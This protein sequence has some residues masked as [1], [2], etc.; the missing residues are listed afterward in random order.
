AGARADR[1]INRNAQP[2]KASQF[3][4]TGDAGCGQMWTDPP[5]SL[6]GRKQP[7]T[8]AC[9][10]LEQPLGNFNSREPTDAFLRRARFRLALRSD[11][12]RAMPINQTA[13]LA[14]GQRGGG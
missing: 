3:R 12:S 6:L 7:M 11:G 4:A 5:P 14:D 13:A 10:A 9:M 1:A 2:V 8:P